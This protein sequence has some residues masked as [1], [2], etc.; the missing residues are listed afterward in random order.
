MILEVS[1]AIII[2][3]IKY[4]ERLAIKLNDPQAAS[5]TC[6]SILKTFENGTTIPVIP[7]MLKNNKLITAFKLKANLFNDFVNQQCS[8]VDNPS[9][10]P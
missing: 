9:S 7:L 10:V 2:A 4:Y 5:K 1:N 8:A 3:K 6:W